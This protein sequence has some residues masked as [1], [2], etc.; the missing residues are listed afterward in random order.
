M[1]WNHSWLSVELIV[2]WKLILS[3]TLGAVV[4]KLFR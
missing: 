3:I 1:E 4:L 2:D